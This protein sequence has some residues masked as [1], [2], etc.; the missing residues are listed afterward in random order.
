M[1]TMALKGGRRRP[2]RIVAIKAS[3]PRSAFIRRGRSQSPH[4]VKASDNRGTE[5][6]VIAWTFPTPGITTGVLNVSYMLAMFDSDEAMPR[7]GLGDLDIEEMFEE[8]SS[9]IRWN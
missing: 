6:A 4:E 9:I 8:Y 3:H 7:A 5:N 2:L 1:P